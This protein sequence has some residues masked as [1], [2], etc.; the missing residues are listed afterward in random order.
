MRILYVEDD[1]NIAEIY[2]VMISDRFPLSEITYHEN[3]QK[4]L[5]ELKLA[6]ERFDLVI[7][8]YKLSNISGADIFAFVSGQ[9]L[10]IPFIILSGLDCSSDEKFSNFFDSHVRNALLLKPVSLSELTEKIEW[11]TGGESDLLK[12]YNR[13]SQNNDEKIATRSD[14]FMKINSVPCDIFLRLRDGKYVKI[15]NNNEVFES[16]LIQKLIMKGVTH[17]YINRSEISKYS[18]SVTSTLSVLMKVKKNKIDDVQKSQLTNKAIEVLKSNLLTCGF[19]KGILKVADEIVNLQLEM[20]ASSSEL[21]SYLNKFQNFRKLNTD[22]TRLVSY[23]IV[24]I[25]HELTW[26]S[27]STLHKMCVAALLHDFSLPDSLIDKVITDN[28]LNELTDD[29]KK[30]YLSHPEESSHLAQHFDSIAT[31]VEQFILEHHELPDGRGFPNKLNFNS[32]HPLSA[33]LHLADL[34]ADLLW[35]YDFNSEQVINKLNEKRQYYQRGHFRKPYDSLM[36]TL[37]IKK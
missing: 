32:I 9:M 4:A 3:G 19:N 2:I 37:K 6:P 29:E 17:F 18:D 36:N 8:D 16:R 23:I 26:N 11:C 33:S 25:L 28:K 15:I 20:I 34:T 13:P 12:I 27:E 31:G 21:E 5:Q 35:E 24:S 30:N 14:S 1:P 7:S 10:G 22:H